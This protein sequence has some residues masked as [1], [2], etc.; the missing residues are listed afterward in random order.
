MEDSRSPWFLGEPSRI[1]LD[2]GELLGPPSEEP[3]TLELRSPV[4]DGQQSRSE[5]L[6]PT[7]AKKSHDDKACT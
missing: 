2:D 7:I 3:P 1:T 4:E 6:V 5:F